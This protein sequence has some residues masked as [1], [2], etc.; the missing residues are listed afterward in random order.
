MFVSMIESS[1]KCIDLNVG[2]RLKKNQTTISGQKCV[3]RIRVNFLYFQD[4]FPTFVSNFESLKGKGVNSVSCVSVNDPF[5]MDAFGKEMKANGKVSVTMYFTSLA[6]SHRCG[7]FLNIL[8][9][10]HA[11]MCL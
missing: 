5:V 10:L 1:L 3:R 9:V 8:I 6:S 4:H 11:H 7:K 2:S